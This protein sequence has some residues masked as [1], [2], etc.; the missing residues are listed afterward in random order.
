MLLVV[1]TGLIWV[2]LLVLFFILV[3]EFGFLVLVVFCFVA[4][5]LFAIT[6]LVCIL[7]LIWLTCL[8]DWCF[9]L[10]WVYSLSC[11]VFG[12]WVYCMFVFGFFVFMV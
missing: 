6:G 9:G 11:F 4:F 10:V 5:L 3:V 8:L 2:A 12:M 7:L 1:Y